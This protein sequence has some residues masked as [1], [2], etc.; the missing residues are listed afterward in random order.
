M[1]SAAAILHQLIGLGQ[2]VKSLKSANF[3]VLGFF[4]ASIKEVVGSFVQDRLEF[5]QHDQDSD[6]PAY[7]RPIHYRITTVYF[8]LLV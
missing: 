1:F 2:G 8:T 5:P 4:C 6:L 7:L 3:A